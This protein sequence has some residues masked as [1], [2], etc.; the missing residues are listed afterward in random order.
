MLLQAICG[1]LASCSLTVFVN[2][3][4]NDNYEIGDRKIVPASPL[5]NALYLRV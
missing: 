4:Y 2:D 1:T 5:E 3:I